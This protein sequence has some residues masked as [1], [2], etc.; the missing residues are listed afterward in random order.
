MSPDG[1]TGAAVSEVAPPG[2]W[3]RG[4]ARTRA[5]RDALLVLAHLVTMVPSEVHSL[6]RREGTA[7]RCLDALRRGRAGTASDRAIAWGI[8]AGQVRETLGRSGARLAA[9]GHDEYPPDLLALPDPPA[10]LFLRGRSAAGWPPGVAIVGARRCTPYGLE[11]A[12]MLG[13][14]LAAAGLMV[15]SGAARGVDA[16]AHRGALAA[17]GPTAAVLGSGID[18]PYPRR[19]RGLIEEIADRGVVLSEYP[20]GFPAEPRRFPARNRI[21]AALA[22]GVVV[23]EGAA[24]SGSLITAEF[25]EDL[26]RDVMAVPGPVTGPLSEAPN[27][28]IRDG[29]QLV[30][31][32]RDVLD[33]IGMFRGS[34]TPRRGSPPEATSPQPEL[35]E[36]E[37]RLL[38]RVP[39][40]PATV[41]AVASAAGI[42]P[43]GALRVLAALE[44]RGL[45]RMEGGR[46][47]RAAPGG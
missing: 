46:Y 7:R 25:A 42:D 23:V 13:A 43:A 36:E 24:G 37:R 1:P 11:V 30:T 21:V 33:A 2:A 38:A 14:D 29:A 19:N 10:S 40:S 26:G 45:V 28:L 31:S 8:D 47:R 4:F 16:A 20:P 5:D 9:P 18:V 35:P 27:A 39:G 44:L 6:A 3:P 34:A 32:A 17:G 15:V 22:R 41:D 12:A